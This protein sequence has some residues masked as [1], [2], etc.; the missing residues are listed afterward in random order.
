MTSVSK[1]QIPGMA[2]EIIIKRPL[3]SV[4]QVIGLTEGYFCA[5]LKLMC[6]STIR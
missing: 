2:N 1:A 4:I 5:N 3:S 6:A